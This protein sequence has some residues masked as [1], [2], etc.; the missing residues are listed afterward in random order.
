MTSRSVSIL[1]ALAF[2][3]S[4]VP[5]AGAEPLAGKGSVKGKVINADGTPAAG[6]NVRLVSP[7]GRKEKL[8]DASGAAKGPGRRKKARAGG[9]P[10]AVAQ[11]NADGSGEFTLAGVPAG[12]YVLAARL[13]ESGAA[14]QPVNVTPNGEA[15][16]TLTLR[17]KGEGK[18]AKRGGGDRDDAKANRKR[19]RAAKKS[20]TQ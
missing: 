12:R 19:A 13:K 18:P 16:V 10:P 11:V 9:Q 8:G 7:A 14:R 17:A 4:I 6:A 20:R 5:A 3:L 2:V 15:N 1:A